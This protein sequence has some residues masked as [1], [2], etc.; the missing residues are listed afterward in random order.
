MVL[1]FWRIRKSWMSFLLHLLRG[2]TANR[3]PL[4][5]KGGQRERTH[6]SYL[7]CALSL[8]PKVCGSVEG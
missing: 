6:A 3:M 8:W 5:S 7:L 4:I 1:S 2:M